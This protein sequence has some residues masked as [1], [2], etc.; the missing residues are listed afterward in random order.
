MKVW[1]TIWRLFLFQPWTI[2][3]ML[4]L[5]VCAWLTYSALAFVP[6]LAFDALLGK[7]PAVLHIYIVAGVLALVELSRIFFQFWDNTFWNIVDY[8]TRSLL[9]RNLLQRILELP[10]MRAIP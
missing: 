2:L 7:E 3:L 5:D 9:Q 4:M 6:K 10:A 8:T 1:Y